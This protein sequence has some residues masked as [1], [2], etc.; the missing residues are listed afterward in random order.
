VA[1]PA[2]YIVNGS[3]GSELDW[4]TTAL[5]AL[6]TVAFGSMAMLASVPIRWF[7][8]L[9]LD[10]PPVHAIVNAVIFAGVGTCMLD[11]FLRV[12]KALEPGRG[13]LYA[14]VWLALV[15][16]IGAELMVLFSVF[17]AA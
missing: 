11:V 4:P 16:V 5:A 14:A 8:G 7:F 6:T 3:L 2:L 17:G 15:A 9:A 10:Y 13:R 12:M 1:L